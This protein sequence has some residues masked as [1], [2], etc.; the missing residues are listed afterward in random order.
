MGVNQKAEAGRARKAQ[1]AEAKKTEADQKREAAEAASWNK[2]ANT[3]KADRDEAAALKADEAARRR[4]EKADLLAAE[5]EALGKGGTAKKAPGGAK[6]KNKKKNDLEL[7]E[8]ALQSAADKKVRKRREDLVKKKEQETKKK[9]DDTEGPPLDPLLANTEQMLG[10]TDV[11][12]RQANV[13]RMQEGATSGIDAALGSLNVSSPGGP[14]SM[15]KSSKA[16]YNEFVAR[17]LPAVKDD[18]PGLR[19][20]QYKEK[21]WQL[22]KKSPDNPA[23]QA[24]VESPPR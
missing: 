21:V 18:Y 15:P 16:L 24:P 4:R 7:L 10:D 2:G 23:N 22:W 1:A 9:V 12:G 5:E 14:Q 13:A 20:T 11:T 6:K 3:R 8:D 19:L 17:M